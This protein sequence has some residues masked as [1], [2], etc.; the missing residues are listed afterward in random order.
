M[1]MDRKACEQAAGLYHDDVGK[2][3]AYVDGFRSGHAAA[4]E[5][6]ET[7]RDPAPF[8]IPCEIVSQSSGRLWNYRKVNA[9]RANIYWEPLRSGPTCVRD[10]THY[11]EIGPLPGEGK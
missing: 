8:N 6:K 2:S 4:M 9:G 11:R 1:D 5:W 10:V 7:E 3:V